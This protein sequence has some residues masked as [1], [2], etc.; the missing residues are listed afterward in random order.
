VSRH[1]L[2]ALAALVLLAG[3]GRA[4]DPQ[5]LADRIDRHLA[6]AH[7]AAKVTPAPA[8]S[9]AEF[10]RRAYLD[11]AGTVPT[12][13]EARAFLD[14]P[15]PDKRAKRIDA[16][17][18]S[19]AAARHLATELRRAWLPQSDAAGASPQAGAFERWLRDRL[20]AGDRYDRLV[21]DVLTAPARPEPGD[22]SDARAFLELNGFRPEDLAANAARSFL[23]L[24][25]DCAQCH[26]HPFARWTQ[27]EFWQTAAFFAPPGRGDTPAARLT[28]RVAG[29]QRTAAP[30]FITGG[31]VP[32]PAEWDDRGGRRA[33]AA[34]A[35]DKENPYFARNAANRA[36]A[37]LFGSGLVEPLDTLVSE[38][39]PPHPELLDDL[40]AAFRDSGHD[41]RFLLAAVARSRA[42]QRTSRWAGGRPPPPHLF[43]RAEVRGLSG[44]QL[45]HAL[46]TAT[47]RPV[48]DDGRPDDPA[49]KLRG[50]F[51]D[52]FRADRPARADR[53]IPQALLL[54]NGEPVAGG[55]RAA[56]GVADAPFLDAGEKLDALFLAALGRRPTAAEAGPHLAHAAT[57]GTG[58]QA[59]AWADVFW[60]LLNSAEFGTN[61]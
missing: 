39:R 24:N 41:L 42:Y 10:L 48:P 19:P 45:F 25:L 15:A 14:D 35:T 28:V 7:A 43:A 22:P 12:V 55:L 11:L 21:R 38:D 54:L 61:H 51:A 60:A 2:V 27:D 30:A 34:W 33:F 6:A 13:A 53:T 37:Q 59:D 31:A 18:A 49:H 5:A 29:T 26:N 36:W 47:G 1:T 44:E 16:L 46:L 32:W 17:L 52:R 58:R 23:G 4:A 3:P 50:Q 57:A 20:A 8:A 9:D 56:R 40:A